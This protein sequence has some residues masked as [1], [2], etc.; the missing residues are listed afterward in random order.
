MGTRVCTGTRRFHPHTETSSTG[1]ESTPRPPGRPRDCDDEKK[2]VA[3]EFES[4]PEHP[5]RIHNL[6]RIRVNVNPSLRCSSCGVS[7]DFVRL[8]FQ[9][10]EQDAIVGSLDKSATTS[11]KGQVFISDP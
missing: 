5:T 1:K 9:R 8:Y 7:V 11:M 4:P 6:E 10:I 2:N 3:A